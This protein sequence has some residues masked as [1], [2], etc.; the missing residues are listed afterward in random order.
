MDDLSQLEA[1]IQELTKRANALRTEKR[2]AIVSELLKKISEN[3]ISQSELFP[4]S[5][6]S[7]KPKGGKTSVSAT[8]KFR[9]PEGETWSGRGLTPRWLTALIASGKTK[10]D[11]A[12]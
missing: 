12:V 6:S 2:A 11:F 5:T 9:G 8:V 7:K 1:Q 3:N 10:E 4:A